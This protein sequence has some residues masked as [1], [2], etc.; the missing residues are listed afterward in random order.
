[1]KQW[2]V[3]G[4]PEITIVCNVFLVLENLLLKCTQSWMSLIFIF[5]ILASADETPCTSEQTGAMTTSSSILYPK[6]HFSISLHKE[7]GELHISIVEGNKHSYPLMFLEREWGTCELQVNRILLVI[8][9]Q[10][11]FQRIHTIWIPVEML[12]CYKKTY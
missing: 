1:M 7:N 4:G 5:F 10:Q 8:I 9:Y 3:P 2:K 11:V 12:S 6:L